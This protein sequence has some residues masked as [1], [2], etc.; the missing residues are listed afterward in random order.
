MAEDFFSRIKQAKSKSD[1]PGPVN[2]VP[3][4]PVSCLQ[5]KTWTREELEEHI[6]LQ[7][8]ITKETTILEIASDIMKRLC[9][10]EDGNLSAGDCARWCVQAAVA[11]I[12]YSKQAAENEESIWSEDEDCN[13]Y[14][15]AD[16]TSFEESENYGHY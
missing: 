9:T 2:P 3:M 8:K 13:D 6:K 5:P 7:D 4:D 15:Y 16:G 11:L 10:R 1:Q 14:L 12:K